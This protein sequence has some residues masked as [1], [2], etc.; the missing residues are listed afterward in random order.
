MRIVAS[1]SF[2]DV[3]KGEYNDSIVAVKRLRTDQKGAVGINMMKRECKI[4]A[5]LHHPGAV[6]PSFLLRL[7]WDAA[8]IILL[9]GITG[10]FGGSIAMVLEWCSGGELAAMLMRDFDSV[11]HCHVVG[12]LQDKIQ[13][14]NFPMTWVD[15]KFDFAFTIAVGMVS[16]HP[17][18][19]V[20]H[21][22]FEPPVF[23][24]S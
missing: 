2:G 19:L 10:S 12:E 9:I 18:L 23:R 15:K 1:G 20:L 5:K 21:A 16:P 6:T 3:F 13:D 11:A 24:H 17:N 8:A 14:K 4:M 7:T 22:A